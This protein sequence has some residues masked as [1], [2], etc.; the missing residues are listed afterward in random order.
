VNFAFSLLLWYNSLMQKKPSKGVI[1]FAISIIVLGVLSLLT[2]LGFEEILKAYAPPLNVIILFL[3]LG[4]TIAEIIFAVGLLQLK[5]RARTGII[6]TVV[7]AII[8]IWGSTFA[9][10]K[11]YTEDNAKSFVSSMDS[12][13][14]PEESLDKSLK[15]VLSLKG[16]DKK[17]LTPEQKAKIKSARKQALEQYSEMRPAIIKGTILFI[18]ALST[19]LNFTIIFFFTRP[20]VKEQFK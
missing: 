18:N 14:T 15:F 7:L 16:L 20:K 12:K 10:K 13:E 6:V 11:E 17:D 2:Y 4:L 5:E 19:L 8:F 3:G 1:A 9:V